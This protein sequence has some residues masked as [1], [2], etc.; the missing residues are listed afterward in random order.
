MSQISSNS[1]NDN[2]CE[3]ISRRN[4]SRF[5]LA[6][7]SGALKRLA[8]GDESRSHQSSHQILRL[9]VSDAAFHHLLQTLHDFCPNQYML[10]ILKSSEV[11]LIKQFLS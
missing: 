4:K 10:V 5:S 8:G 1:V 11:V 7:D 9:F 2:E 3:F 6:E